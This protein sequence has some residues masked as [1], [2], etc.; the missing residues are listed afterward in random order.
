[1][2]IFSIPLYFAV[3]WNRTTDTA[4]KSVLLTRF[5]IR[6]GSKWRTVFSAPKKFCEFSGS[7]SQSFA[8][9]D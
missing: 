5:A 7:L 1:M 2:L 8:F 6:K 4:P 9:A 3:V